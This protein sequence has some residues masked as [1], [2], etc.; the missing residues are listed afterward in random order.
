MNEQ[1]LIYQLYVKR[2]E[3]MYHAP[4]NEEL[5]F[6]HSVKSGDIDTIK[7]LEHADFTKQ[8]GLGILSEN[9][10]WNAKY[11]FVIATAMISRYCIES[12]MEHELAYSASD[13]YIQTV[14]KC[15]SI[16]KIVALQY[17]MIL[18]Y[19][20]YMNK[21]RT[22][23]IYSLSITRCID[24]IY[25]NLH[26]PLS[27]KDLTAVTGLSE[28]YLSRQFKK[29]TGS[30]ISDY[31]K[32]RKLETAKNML[33]HSDFPIS[34]I[35]ETLCFASQSYF[36]KLFREYTGMT[37]AIYRKYDSRKLEISSDKF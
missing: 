35:S 21:L 36:I 17:D 20:T 12:G 11:H 31:I 23:K 25:H 5:G 1:K 29:E 13:M 9:I 16:P 7:R 26:T 27:R 2:E 6:Y 3:E 33:I 10:L 37:P 28:G 18:Y 24:Y 4:Y 22:S 19:T 14:D 30:T 8:P 15:D 32:K 34:M